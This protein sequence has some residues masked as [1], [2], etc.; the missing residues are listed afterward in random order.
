MKVSDYDRQILVQALR[1][2]AD[3]NGGEIF[4]RAKYPLVNIMEGGRDGEL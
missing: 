3:S 2:L 4:D 1:E